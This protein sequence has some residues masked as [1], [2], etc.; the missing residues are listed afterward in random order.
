MFCYLPDWANLLILI[1]GV[2]AFVVHDYNLVRRTEER[3]RRQR[4]EMEAWNKLS[5]EEQ[6]ASIIYG[7]HDVLPQ[8][9]KRPDS[10]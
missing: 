8:R 3:V 6:A 5:P 2:W 10:P 9:T 7:P 1:A 4:D